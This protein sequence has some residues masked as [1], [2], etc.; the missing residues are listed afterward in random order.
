VSEASALDKSECFIKAW[1]L[2][3][4]LTSTLGLR[5]FRLKATVAAAA[6]YDEL[7]ALLPAITDAVGAEKIRELRNALRA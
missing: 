6:G 3:I 2:A 1:P 7:L 5:G 4:R